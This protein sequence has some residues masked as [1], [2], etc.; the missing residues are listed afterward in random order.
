[1]NIPR[2]F[3]YGNGYVGADFGADGTS[4]TLTVGLPFGEKVPMPIDFVSNT[5]KIMGTYQGTEATPLASLVIDFNSGHDSRPSSSFSSSIS[6]HYRAKS[7]PLAKTLFDG[8]DVLRRV[9]MI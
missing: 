8:R 5:D 9:Y 1:M 7:R 6:L 4:G 3:P 2:L